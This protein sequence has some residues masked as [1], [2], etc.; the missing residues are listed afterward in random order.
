MASAQ[1]R[2]A[3]IHEDPPRLRPHGTCEEYEVVLE[4]AM[5]DD[6]VEPRDS[7]GCVEKLVKIRTFK[8]D[9]DIAASEGLYDV[10]HMGKRRELLRCG[11]R[12]RSR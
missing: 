9:G 10:G 2:M 7:I 6:T 12:S 11:A 5:A 3:P 8:I 4:E 1:M